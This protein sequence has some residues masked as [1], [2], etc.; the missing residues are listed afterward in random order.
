MDVANSHNRI[1]DVF[2]AAGTQ[3][4][5]DGVVDVHLGYFDRSSPLW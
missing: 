2:L 5:V 4:I 1:D 3:V